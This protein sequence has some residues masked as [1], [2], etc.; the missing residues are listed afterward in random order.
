MSIVPDALYHMGGVPVISDGVASASMFG[1]YWFVDNVSGSISN[2]GKRVD[3]AVSTIAAAVALA[4]SGD[5][6]F[7]R[8]TDTDYDEA[9]TCALDRVSFIGVAAHPMHLGWNS[10][11][12][13]S[14]L[15][16][17]GKACLVQGFFFRPDGATT[18]H[19]I[20]ISC[21]AVIGQGDYTIIQGNMFKSTGTTCHSAIKAQDEPIYVKVYNNHFSHVGY[22]IHSDGS[23]RQIATGWEI[24]GNYFSDQCTNG[25]YLNLRRSLIAHNYFSTMTVAIDTEGASAGASGYNNVHG[26]Y[27]GGE[28]QNSVYKAASNDDWSGNFS[29]SDDHATVGASGITIANPTTST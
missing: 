5:T 2:G 22:A 20:N 29:M 27:L 15:T 19:A 21:T 24:V 26:N 16:L 1:N 25:I 7:V 23:A 6:I 17:T 10:D 3:D 12:D 4:A 11:A 18:G 14:C 9:V 8:G 28:Y 13:T